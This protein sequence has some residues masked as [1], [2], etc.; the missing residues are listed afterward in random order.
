[1]EVGIVLDLSVPADKAV[2]EP[3]AAALLT[4]DAGDGPEPDQS[5]RGHGEDSVHH[6]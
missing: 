3:L 6:D 1:M 5:T 4:S 2:T